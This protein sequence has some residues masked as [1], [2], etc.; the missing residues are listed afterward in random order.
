MLRSG[1]LETLQRLVARSQLA[2]ARE[3][4]TDSAAG[5][6]ATPQGHLSRGH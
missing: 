6:R 3:G 2:G 1:A 4:R 5:R